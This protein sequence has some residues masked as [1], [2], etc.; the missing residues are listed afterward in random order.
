[1]SDKSVFDRLNEPKSRRRF[2]REG[3]V[4]ALAVGV[5]AACK[6]DSPKTPV[7][8]QQGAAAAGATGGT[9]GA[10]D[11]AA[12]AATALAN[13]DAM[14]AMHEKGIKAFP[15]KTAGM[16]NQ[17]IQ[18]KLDGNVKVYELTA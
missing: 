10:H 16:G 5:G 4:A 18:P 13:A 2:L 17:L 6:G 9:M 7:V 12:A 11:P 15:A 3:G 14:D 8:Q 1:M